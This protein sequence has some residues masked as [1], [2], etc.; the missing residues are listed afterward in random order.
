MPISISCNIN[1]IEVVLEVSKITGY[2]GKNI[3]EESS[4][5]LIATTEDESSMLD[6][7]W[8]DSIAYLFD[9]VKKYNSTILEDSDGVN[10]SF[11]LPSSFDKNLTKSIQKTLSFFVINWMC[12]KWFNLSK[13][14]EVS[15]YVK[16]CERIL[17]NISRLMNARNKPVKKIR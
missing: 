5:D 2:T 9:S 12:S 16:E 6:T 14:D 15:Y 8:N 11:E 1:K 7:F 17:V 3:K 10:I 13:K 4:F